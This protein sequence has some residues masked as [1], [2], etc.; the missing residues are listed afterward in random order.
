MFADISDSWEGSLVPWMQVW[1]FTSDCKTCEHSSA[2]RE[3]FP[4]RHPQPHLLAFQCCQWS[5]TVVSPCPRRT[6]SPPSR[7][8]SYRRSRM[9]STSGHRTT[10]SSRCRASRSSWRTQSLTMWPVGASRTQCCSWRWSRTRSRRITKNWRFVNTPDIVVMSKCLKYFL[11]NNE[12]LLCSLSHLLATPQ[13]FL[14][15][16][17]ICVIF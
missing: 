8:R 10:R 12:S 1:H 16:R 6:S 5:R 11:I 14:S 15:E 2:I 13:P 4:S 3:I 7:G 9:S 17:N